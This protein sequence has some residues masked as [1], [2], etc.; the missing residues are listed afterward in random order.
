LGKYV[1]EDIARQLIADDAPLKP[2]RARGVAMVMDV[3]GFTAFSAAH[4]PEHVI[5]VLDDFLA[6]ATHA[7]SQRSGVVLSYLGDGFLVTFNAPVACTEPQVSACRV[8]ADLFD[9]A[10]RHGFDIRIG[11]ATGDLVTGTIGTD[12]R[13]SFT[14]YGDPVNLA[15]RLEALAKTV[16]EKVLMDAETASAL[17]SEIAP[18][19][20]GQFEIKGLRTSEAVFALRP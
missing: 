2:Q 19:P 8:A 4:D 5:R 18:Q 7:V 1:P 11:I 10:A 3:A 15:A 12:T 6:D 14:V 20:L 17:P 13:Q 9:V 16:E